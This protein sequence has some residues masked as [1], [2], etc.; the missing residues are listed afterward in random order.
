[1]GYKIRQIEEEIKLCKVMSVEAVTRVIPSE[2]LAGV[3]QD[4]GVG[5][6]R[7]RKLPAKLMLLLCIS[8]SLFS[9]LNLS[10]VLR[11]LARGL[12]LL[13]RDDE[14]A[15]ASKGAISQARYRLGLRPLEVLFRRVCRPI[16]APSTPGAFA[17]GL[18]L[19]AL[20]GSIEDAADTPDNEAAFGRAHNG[21]GASAF[22]QVQCV[23]IGECG[24]HVIFD[25]NFWPY[26][27]SERVGGEQL[28]RSIDATM[29]VMWDRGFHDFDMVSA[30]R[31][32]GAHVLAR[33]PAHIKPQRVQT[34]SDGSYLAYLTPSDYQ[35]R[36]AGERLLVRVIEYTLDDPARPGHAQRHR[37]VTTL[38]DP[39][40]YPALDL[41]CLYHERWEVEVTIDEF[42]THQRLLG[43]PLRSR[44]PIGV[45]QELYAVLIAHFVV[46]F[47]MHQSALDHQLD[48]DRLSF[49]QAVQLITEAIHDFQLVSPDQHD[50]LWRRLLRE[51]ARHPLPPRQNRINPRVV[52]RKMSNFKLK[53]PAHLAPPQPIRSFRDAVILL[54]QEMPVVI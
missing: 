27:T 25:A 17:Y 51:M 43:R 40:A 36:K 30:V 6:V 22:P 54:A 2:T 41:V 26:Q 24:T 1:M 32:R 5:E 7:L 21:R 23:Y 44:K 50:R 35:R 42:K 31:G 9:A 46:R 20:D 28:L 38:L 53:R 14:Q 47:I 12:R 8:M 4:C 49:T 10:S 33:L 3:I 52:K 39:R 15:L 18:R 45:L 37:L 29:L 16:A 11:Q 13:A 48:P 34:L 19:V